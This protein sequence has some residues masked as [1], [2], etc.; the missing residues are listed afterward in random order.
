[1]STWQDL[2]TASL[3]GTE[4]AVVPALR[5]PGLPAGAETAAEDPAAILLD[6]AAMATAARRAG[7]AANRAE[8]LPAAEPDRR[9]AVSPAAGGAWPGCSPESTRTC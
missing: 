1:M 9:P 4:R 8:P 6:W 7:R 5:I 3:I 2:V